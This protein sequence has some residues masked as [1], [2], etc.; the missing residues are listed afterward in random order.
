MPTEPPAPG[1][2]DSQFQLPPEGSGRSGRAA[3]AEEAGQEFRPPG[4]ALAQVEEAEVSPTVD[5]LAAIPSALLEARSGM[6]EALRRQE[7]A[8]VLASSLGTITGPGNIQ[9]VAIGVGHAA[10]AYGPLTAEPGQPTLMVFVAEHASAE[11][12]QSVIVESLGVE[13][14][15]SVDVP[16]TPVVTG[17]IDAHPHRFR[18]RPSPGG[19]SV[20]HFKVTAGTIGALTL[21]RSSP[22][23]ERLMIL[24]NNH[25]LANA[26]NA[27]F[28]DC[29]CQ[30][31]PADGGSCPADQVAIL[32]R[33]VPLAFG[34]AVN[35]VDCATAWAWPDRVRREELYLAGGRPAYMRIGS[36]PVAAQLG[37]TVGK[38]GR[39]TQITTGR[40]TGIG[41][42]LWVN[43][44]GGR[45]AFFE[46]Q[47]SIQAFSGNFSEGGDSGS[48]IWTW[49]GARSP[50]GLLYAGGG[51][52]TF[53]NRIQRVLTALDVT[54]YT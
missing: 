51:G 17:I 8:D 45:S 28:G 10:G 38:S 2:P 53:A 24:S 6:A 52:V 31:G 49:D 14:A 39:T 20:A 4:D 54:L 11:H 16:V 48:L 13:A 18:L 30:P 32:E 47:I 1:R 40:V 9:G 37:M 26:N 50:V 34:G 27:V 41:A 19:I 23:N 25:V 29:V 12:I 46:D 42:S 33:F 43:Y 36:Q 15:A 22:R 35:Y 7:P 5:G 3:D 44:S 21:G